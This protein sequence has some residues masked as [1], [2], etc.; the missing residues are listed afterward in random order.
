MHEGEGGSQGGGDAG[1]LLG[2]ADLRMRLG[3]ACGTTAWPLVAGG[4]GERGGMPPALKG[5]LCSLE[6]E[7]CA[8]LGDGCAPGGPGGRQAGGG[9]AGG[10]RAGEGGILEAEWGTLAGGCR[11]LQGDGAGRFCACT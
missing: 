7:V 1:I 6:A 4:G 2:V 3:E 9:D 10:I 11:T 5:D 8:A